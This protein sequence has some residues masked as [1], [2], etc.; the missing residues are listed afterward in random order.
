LLITTEAISVNKRISLISLGA[1]ATLTL[2]PFGGNASIMA[3]AVEAGKS[4]IATVLNRPTVQ[5][6]LVADKKVTQ[7]DAQGNKSVGWQALANGSSVSQGDVV[8]YTVTGANQGDRPAKNLSVSQPIVSGFTYV[9]NSA[10]T[11]GAKADVMFSIDGGKTF[12]AQPTVAVTLA[13]GKVEYKPAPTSA[14][15]NVRWTFTEPVGPKAK[16]IATYQVAVR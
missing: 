7:K 15:S 11:K 14:Y 5:L 1:A 6:N 13:D 9:A 3:Q 12:S 4:A 8:R 16:A 10:V 2:V